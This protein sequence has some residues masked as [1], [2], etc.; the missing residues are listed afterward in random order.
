MKL[1]HSLSILFVLLSP[2]LGYSQ[3]AEI[4]TPKDL[5]IRPNWWNACPQCPSTMTNGDIIY[6]I[7]PSIKLYKIIYPSFSCRGSIPD[8]S[9]RVIED[10]FPKLTQV[11]ITKRLV[12]FK[13]EDIEV[14]LRIKRYRFLLNGPITR[15][16]L[17]KVEV[18]E[19]CYREFG[20]YIPKK[21]WKYQSVRIQ[22]KGKT[23][24]L[25]KE[26]FDKFLQPNIDHFQCYNNIKD[27]RLYI[28]G[29]NGDGGETTH[30]L[31]LIKDGKY[32][33]RFLSGGN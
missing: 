8:S 20:G 6:V 19:K 7:A 15:K 29:F 32:V 12:E 26:A 1:R 33:D 31:W 28:I 9:Y 3:F 5:V 18:S 23:L 24:Y 10:E 4:Y 11:R 25:P 16:K 21:K 27:S 13:S 30:F 17:D 2:I 14:Q 22:I